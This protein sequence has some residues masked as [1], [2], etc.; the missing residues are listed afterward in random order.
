M[1][2]G[3]IIVTRE[4]IS[5]Y[6]IKVNK[7]SF[8]IGSIVFLVMV[9]LFQF[10]KWVS[11]RIFWDIVCIAVGVFLLFGF[12]WRMRNIQKINNGTYFTVTTD[13]LCSK[14]DHVV[15]VGANAM[16]LCFQCDHYTMYFRYID[17]YYIYLAYDMDYQTLYDIASVGDTY[18]L[19]KAKKDVL[20]AYNN[21][22]FDVQV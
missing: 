4:D 19:I 2:D 20:L 15:R 18:T 16:R 17:R 10:C 13:V 5:E 8:M 12:L 22:F 21:K 6:F 11:G 7:I 3:R 9:L 14:N 1:E